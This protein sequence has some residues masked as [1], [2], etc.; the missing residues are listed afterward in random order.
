M[1]WMVKW[2]KLLYT[3]VVSMSFS[4]Y[5]YETPIYNSSFIIDFPFSY[6]TP[7]VLR[8]RKHAG[9]HMQTGNPESCE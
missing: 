6:S 9:L 1:G 7:I 2:K 3:I 8:A 4:Q 5:P